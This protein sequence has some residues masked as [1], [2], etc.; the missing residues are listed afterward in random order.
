MKKY[1]STGLLALLTTA[2]LTSC[3]DTD[4][5]GSIIDSKKQAF[6]NI[7]IE[8]YGQP[9]PQQTW[10]F[11]SSSTRGS[12]FT[13]SIVPTGKNYTLT[14]QPAS[15]PEAPS[16]P[17]FRSKVTPTFS[18]SVPENTPEA[19]STTELNE[20]WSYQISTGSLNQPQNTQNLTFYVVDNVEWSNQV[21]AGGNGTTFIVTAGKKLTYTQAE[22][23][24]LK[25][26]M[27]PGSELEIGD[28]VTFGNS[29]VVYVG[30]G[31]TVTF[32]STVTFKAGSTLV[33]DGATTFTVNT[34]NITEATLFYNDGPLTANTE[35][36]VN[37]M[38]GEGE[39][40][41]AAELV[42]ASTITTPAIN[43]EAGGGMYTVS[44]A[45]TTVNGK[46]YLYNTNS[47]WWNDGTYN[48]QDFE[49]NSIDHVWNTCKLTVHKSDNTG[50]F[51]I[52]GNSHTS[53]VLDAN[54][55]VQT[56]KM[57]WGN[58]ADFYMKA[59]SM[60]EVLGD[61][62]SYNANKN[63]G[64]HG[65][66][67]SYS[68]FKAGSVTYKEKVQNCM[69]YYGN[70][71]VDTDNHFEQ[72]LLDK[73]NLSEASD[74][75]TFYFNTST[76]TVKFKFYND[77]CPITQ[78]I[79]ST[80][81]CHHGYNIP[82]SSG[83]YEDI[84]V[85]EIIDGRIFCED[86]G[87]AQRTDIDYND[88]VFDAF[89]YL[90]HTYR[91]P[92]T[93]DIDGNK[94]YDYASKTL[95]SSVYNKTDINL[96]AAGGTIDISVAD[97]DVNQMMSIGKTLMANTYVE[98]VSPNQSGYTNFDNEISPVKFT[99]N[100]PNYS[101]LSNI[102][103]A[104][105]YGQEVKELTAYIGDVPQ[106]FAAPVGT[107]WP[108]ERVEF[109]DAFTGFRAWV[110]NR[111]ATPWYTKIPS[112]LYNLKFASNSSENQIGG[113]IS[114]WEAEDGAIKVS[115]KGKKSGEE[116]FITIALN[117]PLAI[118]DQIA[119]TGYRNRTDNAVGSLYFLFDN[120]Y[121]IADEQVYNNKSY[122][123]EP[124]TFVWTV[125]NN[126]AGCSSFKLSR[127][128]TGTNV[129]ITDI[130]IIS[131]L[132][133]QQT[134]TA[135]NSSSGEET[136]EE[137]S[138][139]TGGNGGGG[140]QTGGGTG[141]MDFSNM[142]TGTVVYTNPNP[143][144]LSS[145]N[146]VYVNSNDLVNLDA[147]TIYVYGTGTGDVSV[148]DIETEDVT[149][150]TSSAPGFSFTRTLGFTRSGETPVV[151]KC[152]LGPAHLRKY[153]QNALDIKGSNFKVYQVSYDASQ[154][155]VEQPAGK[156]L[157][158]TSKVMNWDNSKCTINGSDLGNINA[159]SIIHVAGVGYYGW[160]AFV[161][162]SS[163]WKKFGGDNGNKTY[164]T[165]GDVTGEIQLSWTLSSLTAEEIEDLKTGGLTV[166]GYNFILKYVT[167]ET[168]SS[169]GGSTG[170]ATATINLVTSNTSL[171][172]G[173][174]AIVSDQP[175]AKS[176]ASRIVA[177]TSKLVAKIQVNSNDSWYI[178]IGPR[179]NT[180]TGIMTKQEGSNNNG[181]EYTFETDINSDMLESI[182]SNANDSWWS[183]G[184][185]GAQGSNVTIKELKL[186]NC[187][188]A[189]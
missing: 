59:N 4:F 175:T 178:Q 101:D 36:N 46:T 16:R 68:I 100:N 81:G 158:N 109:N 87:S 153:Y 55:S 113:T 86:L 162:I 157:F 53:F 172:G 167:I 62:K 115:G 66:G 149:P 170:D 93:T 74:Q 27:A 31:C 33:N 166:Q 171:T 11:G 111:N 188:P 173:V 140:N 177:G 160:Q 135:S 47:Y 12:A 79:S 57:Y 117:Q 58:N 110:A 98:N 28:G 187:L 69:N 147:A 85:Q 150:S 120:N 106:K 104:V 23:N 126:T 60:L 146:S 94:E 151:K 39:N 155:T 96:L 99:V 22:A 8:A 168:P 128:L 185:F 131:G 15:N 26:Y 30:S 29:A 7:F 139:E 38:Y 1:L 14:N 13:R 103:V 54:A 65:L 75:P 122:G 37:K 70:V 174:V 17:T 181:S 127:N 129:Y 180:G 108:A 102:P 105:R 159:N 163:P 132:G 154:P 144:T 136:G 52:A 43:V 78:S 32:G 48:T 161:A 18:A 121:V 142:T 56:D 183:G 40:S 19:T 71:W 42:N 141:D 179:G 182:Q 63:H 10:G 64:I 138:E 156:V 91:V 119:I 152:V 118:G 116:K 88:V 169:T 49:I 184:M 67:S 9:D 84:A 95:V 50:E 24:N 130:T 25:I 186:T 148:N 72:E 137:T 97:Q 21:N 2:Y 76:N 124:N 189:E 134:G 80:G 5:S 73:S 45:T 61:C 83:N 164:W 165:E 77:I 107:P 123:S 92:Y 133:P 20:G 35:I 51:K 145:N 114:D 125:D 90:T 176:Y 3:S 143:T 6:S 44:G 89:T 34:L 112:K 41:K 82:E